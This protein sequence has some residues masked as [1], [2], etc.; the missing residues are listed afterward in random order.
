MEYGDAVPMSDTIAEC[1]I[2]DCRNADHAMYSEMLSMISPERRGKAESYAMFED[3][4]M[5]AAAGLCISELEKRFDDRVVKD[6]SGKPSFSKGRMQLSISHSGGFASVAVSHDPIGIDIQKTVPMGNISDRIVTE[7]EKK[8]FD[9]SDDGSV[10]DLWAMKESYLKMEGSG[11]DSIDGVEV[12]FDEGYSINGHPVMLFKGIPG[13]S[14]AVC[15]YRRGEVTF[16]IMD[17]ANLMSDGWDP[18]QSHSCSPN[19]VDRRHSH[20]LFAHEGD[21]HR[22]TRIPNNNIL[23]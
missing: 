6:P 13:Y 7:H 3:K 4:V 16:K 5:S 22:V 2:V 19:P 12:A 18:K 15:S 21:C 1:I 20:G 17:L 9:G 23:L 8:M 14:M 10:C 11:I